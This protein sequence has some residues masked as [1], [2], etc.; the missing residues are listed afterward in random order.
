MADALL[1]A[2]LL[3]LAST[4]ALPSV[5]VARSAAGTTS[6]QLPVLLTVTMYDLPLNSTVTFWPASTFV[7][8]PESVRSAP[9]SAALITSSAVTLLMVT[10]GAAVFTVTSWVAE[11]LLPAALVT[12]TDTV[13][14]PSFSAVISA[15]G[16]PTLQLPAASTTVV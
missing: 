16:T 5:R 4:R 9:C 1:P 11:P 10:T 2:A 7:V 14:V 8:V 12:V 3:T 6:V 15:A 13:V